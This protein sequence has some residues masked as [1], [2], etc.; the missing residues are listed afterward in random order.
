MK[1][2]RFHICALAA[3]LLSLLTGCGSMNYSRNRDGGAGIGERVQNDVYQAATGNGH[4]GSTY[5]R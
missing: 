5:Q 2:P 4:V 1:L 3:L